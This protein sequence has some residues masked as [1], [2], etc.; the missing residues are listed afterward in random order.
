MRVL[1]K[2]TFNYDN[3]IKREIRYSLLSH[4]DSDEPTEL[5]FSFKHIRSD[6]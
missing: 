1:S 2:D 5:L 3:L 6:Q 4:S